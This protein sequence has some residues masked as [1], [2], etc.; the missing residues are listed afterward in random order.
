MTVIHETDS[1]VFRKLLFG[2]FYVYLKYVLNVSSSYIIDSLVCF[3]HECVFEF[4]D[5]FV[6]A[7]W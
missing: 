4:I 1:F 2:T 3:S 7:I 6:Q 5:V